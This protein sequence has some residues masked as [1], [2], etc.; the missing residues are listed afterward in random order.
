MGKK[1]FLL[2]IPIIIIIAAVYM[3]FTVISPPIVVA[4]LTVNSGTAEYLSNGDWMAAASGQQL[5]QGDSVR[6]LAGSSA[7]IIFLESSVL[8]L[9]ESTTITIS[10]LNPTGGDSK[11]SIEQEAGKTWTKILR[12]SGI[13][14]Y[15]IE[16]PNTVATVRG[17]GFGFYVFPDGTSGVMLHEGN[18]T[19]KIFELEDGEKTILN[20][21][22]LRA[23]E[24]MQID[25]S[26]VEGLITVKELIAEGALLEIEPIEK[27]QMMR[28]DFI[29]MNI[30][31]DEAHISEVR[32]KLMERLGPVMSLM[33]ERYGFTEEEMKAG[34]DG[35]LRGEHRLPKFLEDL[36][37]RRT[38]IT[39]LTSLIGQAD[40]AIA[41][42]LGMQVDSPGAIEDEPSPMEPLLRVVPETEEEPSEP[43]LR[44]EPESNETY[45]ERTGEVELV[46]RNITGV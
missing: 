14:E 13:S 1:K 19:L 38:S 32:D 30:Q 11:I 17:T 22:K 9:D 40:D 31:S 44:V 10:E 12:L 43:L 23:G 8:R 18:L 35:Y 42:Q 3:Y 41:Q 37:E 20:T 16:S 5:T 33:T 24:M 28:D 27:M 7:T 2:I 4:E 6:T 15:N 21:E 36:L 45:V 25:D 39:D 29:N 26:L 34:V 46:Q